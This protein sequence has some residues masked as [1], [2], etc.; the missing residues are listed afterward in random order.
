MLG[1]IAQWWLSN[2]I[3]LQG[4]GLV[5][6]GYA[7]V[8][9]LHGADERDYHYGLRPKPS[10]RFTHRKDRDVLVDHA[11]LIAFGGLK[12]RALPKKHR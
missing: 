12:S 8:G 5:G 10:L 4:T 7:A 11:M 2:S 3:A 1:T 6:A 9:T